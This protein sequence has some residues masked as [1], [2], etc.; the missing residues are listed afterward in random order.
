MHP[1]NKGLLKSG[2]SKGCDS[3]GGGGEKSE[4][5]I[6][7]TREETYYFLVIKLNNYSGAGNECTSVTKTNSVPS[8]MS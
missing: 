7:V 6:C 1:V 8:E 2:Y 5:S 3:C 4:V